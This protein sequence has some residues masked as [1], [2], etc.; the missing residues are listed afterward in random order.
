MMRHLELLRGEPLL[1]QSAPSRALREVIRWTGEALASRRGSVPDGCSLLQQLPSV[2]GRSPLVA[3]DWHI[4]MSRLI[5]IS[6]EVETAWRDALL[7]AFVMND[8][9]AW[10]NL[11]ACQAILTSVEEWMVEQWEI[12]RP[13][14]GALRR[15][16]VRSRQDR[17]S[18]RLLYEI[19][20]ASDGGMKWWTVLEVPRNAARDEIRTAFHHLL[21]R[22]HRC[23]KKGAT[24][25]LIAKQASEIMIRA[26]EDANRSFK[27][28]RTR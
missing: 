3:D 14:S 10:R 22:Y 17:A 24:A 18:R 26:Y 6:R 2:L 19:A 23:T 20:V 15:I 13:G 8:E 28:R 25:G 4:P 21:K 1:R 5:R 7:I 11:D 9:D 12:A 16:A 27:E